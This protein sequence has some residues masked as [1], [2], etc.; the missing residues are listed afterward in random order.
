MLGVVAAHG[1]SFAFDRPPNL[2]WQSSKPIRIALSR[3][4]ENSQSIL[5][6]SDVRGAL[7]RSLTTWESAAGVNFEVVDSDDLNVSPAGIAGNRIN[8]IT[9]AGTSQ[10]TLFF[11]KEANEAPAATRIFFDRKG[12]IIEA[13]I[14]LNTSEIFSTSGAY[15]TYD[16]ESIFLHE[17]GHLLGLEHSDLPGSVMSDVI[18]KNGVFTSGSDQ[19][20]KLA[21][22]DI[23]AARAIYGNAVAEC[24][25]SISGRLT[26]KN[27]R[28]AADSYVWIED[29]DDGRFVTGRRTD[30]TGQFSIKGIE[31][32]QYRVG[33]ISDDDASR[34]EYEI[35]DIESGTEVRLSKTVAP[36]QI[37]VPVLIGADG[38][39]SVVSLRALPGDTPR[40]FI[41][42]PPGIGG[43][44]TI[45]SLSNQISI[46]P[47]SF[48]RHSDFSGF[49]VTSFSADIAEGVLE[50]EYSLLIE[51]EDGRTAVLP[52]I[53][54][55]D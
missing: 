13:D 47:T 16:L 28:P 15:G 7:L 40:I 22:S 26:L 24:C 31:S 6:G 5:R 48:A 44:F 11:S 35:I 30:E 12:F 54:R 39:L 8:L 18:Q 45:R 55:F 41:G 21:K 1:S 29:G 38:R 43:Q 9:I 49:N 23:A 3:S 34:V 32:G 53:L 10:N 4:F 50:G 14:A 36:R 52:G 33:T 37:A 27:G 19:Q 17:I 51:F 46:D 2:Q 25:G 42:L 20:R